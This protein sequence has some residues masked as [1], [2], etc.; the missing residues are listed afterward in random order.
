MNFK[1]IQGKDYGTH[2]AKLSWNK[3][4]LPHLK[5]SSM[6]ITNWHGPRMK[7]KICP[8]KE[9]NTIFQNFHIN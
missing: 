2:E 5:T 7:F 9:K 8:E 3:P 6:N 4:Q 1:T